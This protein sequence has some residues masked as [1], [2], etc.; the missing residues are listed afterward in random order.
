MLNRYIE[1]FRSSLSEI[2]GAVGGP[3]RRMGSGPGMGY[4]SRP[5][6]Y[7]RGDRFGGANRF[8]PN[9]SRNSRGYKGDFSIMVFVL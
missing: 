6:P 2:N 9:N 8:Q 7:D 3:N 1:I 5:A 4:N